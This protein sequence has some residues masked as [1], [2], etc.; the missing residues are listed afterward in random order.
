MPSA[1][2]LRKVGD[3]HETIACPFVNR[4][5]AD[6]T[7]GQLAALNFDGA[8]TSYRTFDWASS[9]IRKNVVAVTTANALGIVVV[10]LGSVASGKVGVYGIAGYFPV[11][12][13]A[14]VSYGAFLYGT[15]GQ[16]YASSAADQTALDGLAL[17]TGIIG[18]A[19]TASSTQVTAFF[20]GRAFKTLVGGGA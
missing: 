4:T 14:S 17:P 12:V 7:A 6:M 10:A 11:N 1:K 19:L 9:D 18:M 15:N 8:N 3:F 20:D 2:G 16:T 5:G 13:N